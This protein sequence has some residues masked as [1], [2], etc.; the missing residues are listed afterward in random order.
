MKNWTKQDST[1]IVPERRLFFQH[2]ATV[3]VVAGSV[4]AGSRYL[5]DPQSTDPD[6][7]QAGRFAEKLLTPTQVQ[8]PFYPDKLPLDT[9]ND[10]LIINDRI[11]PS[12]GQITHLSGTVKDQKGNPVRGAMVEIWQCDGNGIYHHRRGGDRTKLDTNFQSFGRFRTNLKGEYYFRTIK[13]VSYPGRAPHVHFMVY[14]GGKKQLTTQMYVS[15]HP[16]NGRDGL[17]NSVRDKKQRQMLIVDFKPLAGSKLNELT[18]NF[19]IIIG[20]TPQDA[21]HHGGQQG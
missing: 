2:S 16:L 14:A 18:A 6:F 20:A 19:D 10:L 4:M 3:L 8:G 17:L 5:Q 11:T 15:G 21:D 1:V 12:V 13:P 7:V 9:D